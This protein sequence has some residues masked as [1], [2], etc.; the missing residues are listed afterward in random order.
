MIRRIGHCIF[1]L[2]RSID[3]LACTVWLSLLYPFGLA[4]RP[5]GREFVSS[6]VGE[7][8]FNGHC[9]A[10]RAAAVID[11]CAVRLGDKPN[12]CLRAFR[13]YQYLDD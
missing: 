12:H 11:W 2:L 10:K 8:Q 5:T 1:P 13:K 4:C 7:A 3:I 9:W 6:Y